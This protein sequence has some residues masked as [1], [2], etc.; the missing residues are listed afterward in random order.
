M[1]L[2]GWDRV[3]QPKSAGGLGFKKLDLMNKAFIMKIAWL[4]MTEPKKLVVKVLLSKYGLS[5]TDTHQ[6]FRTNAGSPLWKAVGRAWE[7]TK[8]GLCWSIGDGTTVSFWWDCWVI[9]DQPLAHLALSSIPSDI[10]L[11]SVAQFTLLNGSWN[12]NKFSHLLP[13]HVLL[14]IA[15]IMPPSSSNGTDNFYWAASPSGHFTIRSAYMLLAKPWLSEASSVWKLAWSWKGPQRVR[16]F[17]WQAL[18]SRLKTN[19]ELASRGI[20]MDAACERCGFAREDTL[21][22]LRDCPYS[23][24][25]WKRLLINGAH[26]SFFLDG[27][28]DWLVSNLHTASSH[29][30]LQ[31]WSLTFGVVIWRLWFWR[32]KLMFNHEMWESD[33]IMLDI[34]SRVAEIQ[35]CFNS[36]LG[37]GQ[38]HVEKWIRWSSP[39]W[40]WVKLNTDGARKDSGV[41][42]AGGLV[43]DY[44]GV[45]QVGF[46]VNLGACSVLTA[47]IWGLYHGLC[48]AWQRGFQRIWV[49]VDSK[50]VTQI[51]E[52]PTTPV[53]EH[54][55]LIL[56]IRELLSRDWIVG[57]NHIY[58]E[59]NIAADFLASFSLSFPLGLHFLTKAPPSLQCI[60]NN[61]VAGVAPSRLVVF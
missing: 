14:R 58:R 23:M 34:Y 25:I 52:N 5:P 26:Q 22:V 42:G 29:G 57:V 12:W 39:S 1:S 2:I 15:S 17:I 20:A 54:H 6:N 27:L 21:H 7:P 49:E 32:N 61:D 50:S 59:A 38:R 36:S 47:E 24:A 10:S 51:L 55:S 16:V 53:N 9:D 33:R 28:T 46:C 19:C 45:W 3:C 8:R 41:A 37:A 60:L 13:H 35:R 40:P 44:R 48:M 11:Q 56:A 31:G 43:R 18:H 30:D 4:L